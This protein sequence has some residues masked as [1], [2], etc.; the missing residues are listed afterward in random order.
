MSVDAYTGLLVLVGTIHTPCIRDFTI[1]MLKAAPPSFRT[2]RASKNHHPLD[3]REPGGNSLHTLRVVKLVKLL[4]DV[5]DYDRLT[6]DLVTSA[7]SIHD[8]CRYGL[9]D[10]NEATLKEHALLPRMLAGRHFITCEYAN[11]IFNIAENHMGRWGPNQ[12]FPQACP[13]DIIH[14]AD[15][16][17]ARAHEIW[18]QLGTGPS[19]WLGDVPFT[20]KGMTQEKVDIMEELAEDNEYWKTALSFFRSVSTRK[21]STLSDRQKDWLYNIVDSL[22]VELNRK[23][24]R[25]AF[26]SESGDDLFQ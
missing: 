2:A 10:E 16:L 24:A 7:A 14:I 21:F 23:E 26:E 4:A 8:L 20:D 1:A 11:D 17:S 19:S 22:E 6:T 13:S 18:E 5:C 3:E 12:Y 15:A 9:N 25:K